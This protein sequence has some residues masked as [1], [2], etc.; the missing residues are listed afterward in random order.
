MVLHEWDARLCIDTVLHF[1]VRVQGSTIQ[2]TP[3]STCIAQLYPTALKRKIILRL[4]NVN[5][6]SF[7]LW[8]VESLILDNIYKMTVISSAKKTEERK[9]LDH[10]IFLCWLHGLVVFDTDGNM[11]AHLCEIIQ[12]RVC[13]HINC[14]SLL[15]TVANFIWRG[16]VVRIT[17]WNRPLKS[18]FL[19]GHD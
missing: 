6:I 3:Q 2:G 14:C 9:A 12:T 7:Q 16:V 1:G 15:L 4:Y 5:K 18:Q 17:I 10:L 13:K 19:H 8:I 11:Y